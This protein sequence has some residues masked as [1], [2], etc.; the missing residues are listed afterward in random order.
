MK[1]RFHSFYFAIAGIITLFKEEPN[2]RVHVL[3][4]AIVILMGVFFKITSHEWVCLTVVIGMVICA[5]AFNTS[6][7]CLS[8]A[9][10][11]EQNIHIK[12]AK[13]LAAGGVFICASV[14]V[15][16]GLI[17]FL[18]KIIDKVIT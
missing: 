7:E 17:I 13:D 8:D 1:K 4:A 12:K 3:M 15:N 6:I 11:K 14:S 18:P 2:A 10:T 5:E 9:V 16:I